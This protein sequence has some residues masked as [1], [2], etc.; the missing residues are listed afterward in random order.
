MFVAVVVAV[1]AVVAVVVLPNPHPPKNPTPNTKT[2]WGRTY[3]QLHVCVQGGAAVVYTGPFASVVR[4]LKSVS[5]STTMLAVGFTPVSLLFETDMPTSAKLVLG[6]TIG[7][8][9]LA[10]TGIVHWVTKPYVRLITCSA[11]DAALLGPDRETVYAEAEA[12]G[13][14]PD[15]AAQV[16]AAMAADPDGNIPNPPDILVHVESLNF[17]ARPQTVTMRMSELV[18]PEFPL[19]FVS[20]ESQKGKGYFVHSEI[21]EADPRLANLFPKII[22]D[23]E[24]QR[25]G[26]SQAAS[27]D[28]EEKK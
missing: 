28:S 19:A 7:T 17:F 23:M 22:S 5:V 15:P 20:F 9:A 2:G 21:V 25:G 12:A 11:G 4:I 3:I 13:E 1:V 16:K 24:W 18:W 10:S 6:G 26:D 14:K 27:G 8:F